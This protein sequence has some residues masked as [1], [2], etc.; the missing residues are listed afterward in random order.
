MTTRQLDG[1]ILQSSPLFAG[2]AQPVLD[3]LARYARLVSLD[4]NE[5]LFAEGDESDGC[6]AILDGILKVSVASVDGQETLVAMLGAGEVVGEMGLI[7]AQPR[8]ASATALKPSTLAFLAS[9]DFKRAAHADP[10]IYQH[11]LEILCS[12]LRASN[13][14]VSLQQFLPLRGRLAQVLL[15]LADM[16]GEREDDGGIVIRQKFTQAELARMTGSA[17]ENVNR[18]IVNWRRDGLISRSGVHYRLENVK[19]L[20]RLAKS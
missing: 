3:D 10:D 13:V 9:R 19:E 14:A 2:L 20:E 15:R 4:A 1:S 6:Y 7:D 11:M 8:S 18:Q 16:F 12:R 17:R 5:R